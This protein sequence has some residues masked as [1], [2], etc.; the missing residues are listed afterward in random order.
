MLTPID[1]SSIKLHGVDTVSVVEDKP[2]RLL[3]VDDLAELLQSPV[4]CG[5]LVT[6]KCAIRRVPTSTTTK[7]NW[8]RKVRVTVT[9]KS[10]ARMAWA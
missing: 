4:C 5:M 2:I 8:T 10:Q 6:L 1:F 3:T 7:T 9:K